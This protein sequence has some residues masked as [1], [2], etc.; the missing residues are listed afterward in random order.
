MLKMCSALLPLKKTILPFTP[1]QRVTP[2]YLFGKHTLIFQVQ[3][4]TDIRSGGNQIK[5][6]GN[7]ACTV[8]MRDS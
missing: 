2:L 3:D 6:Y 4:L 7:R 5:A 8:F 1:D